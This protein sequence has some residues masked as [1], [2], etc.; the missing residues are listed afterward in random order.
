[1]QVAL[2]TSEAI[3]EQNGRKKS[4]RTGRMTDKERKATELLNPR[5]SE[6]TVSKEKNEGKPGFV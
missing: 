2:K 6:R 5:N 3:R 4:N 1:M